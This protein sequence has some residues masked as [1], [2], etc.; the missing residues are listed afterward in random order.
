M[1]DILTVIVTAIML[2]GAL[3]F[4]ITY[5]IVT[6]GKWRTQTPAG[7]WLFTTNGLLGSLAMLILL[8]RVAPWWLQWGG[9][10]WVLLG[11]YALYAIKPYWG[12]R[13]LW[14][15]RRRRGE[16]SSHVSEA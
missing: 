5:Q 14:Q 13:L 7:L 15:A 11:V 2:V 16:D 10:E 4:G 12:L 6:D 8:A 9:R 3:I 1:V